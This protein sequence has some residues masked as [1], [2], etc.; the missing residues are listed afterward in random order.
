VPRET[1]LLSIPPIYENKNGVRPGFFSY[2]RCYQQS[3][4]LS[5]STK[6]TDMINTAVWLEEAGSREG[7]Q[8]FIE[9]SIQNSKK[10][11]VFY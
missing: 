9:V 5:G 2:S 6:N 4:P 7:R 11:H 10:G 3:S 8:V 1:S